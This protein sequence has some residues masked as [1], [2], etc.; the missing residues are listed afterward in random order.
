MT[1]YLFHFQILHQSPKK[2]L[3]TQ[4]TLFSNL[5]FSPKTK[6]TPVLTVFTLF[7][8]FLPSSHS[9]YHRHSVTIIIPLTVL[10]SRISCLLKIP[11]GKTYIASIVFLPPSISILKFHEP[12]PDS[13]IPGNDMPKVPQKSHKNDLFWSFFLGLFWFFKVFFCDNC[14]ELF[15][16]TS[17]SLHF[18]FTISVI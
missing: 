10:S 4:I 1:Y 6:N 3:K 16:S 17:K 7:L 2:C 15:C 11:Q 13:E 9:L 5:K 12:L 18:S 14:F 8:L